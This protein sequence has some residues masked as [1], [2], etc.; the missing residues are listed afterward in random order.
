MN[1]FFHFHNTK[2]N[3][4][5]NYTQKQKKWKYRLP[6]KL[7]LSELIAC[8]LHED[9]TGDMI[10]AWLRGCGITSVTDITNVSPD[11]KPY[12]R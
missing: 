6:E 2:N 11:S 5:A 12:S 3:S 9:N 4:F 7:S 10:S 1:R 8:G